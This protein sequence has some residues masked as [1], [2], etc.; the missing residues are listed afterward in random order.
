[1]K[2]G[3]KKFLKSFF[4]T[5]LAVLV[6]CVGLVVWVDPFFNY[7]IPKD[8][9]GYIYDQDYAPTWKVGISRHQKG[10][11]SIWVGSSLSTYVDVNYINQ[12]FNVNCTTGVIASGRPN[13]Y[14]MFIQNAID[15][16]EI[17]N[18]YYE[19]V[20][21]HWMWEPTGTDYDMSVIPEYIQT[22]AIFD[23]G[24][25]LFNKNVLEQAVLDLEGKR[26]TR[27]EQKRAQKENERGDNG[28]QNQIIPEDTLFSLEA[29]APRMYSN[30]M[31]NISEEDILKYK[32][33]GLKN[34][35]KNIVPL[36]ESNP[37]IEFWFVVPPTGVMN[38]SA[39]CNAGLIDPYIKAEKSIYLRLL[40]YKNVHVYFVKGDKEFNTNLNHYMDDGHFCPEGAY[41]EVDAIGTHK[42][43]LTKE[44]I[45]GV[46]EAA[47]K[48]AEDF[49]W[50]FLKVNFIGNDVAEFQEQLQ[51]LGYQTDEL[52]GFGTVTEQSVKK[53][54]EE[55]GLE[56]T[57]IAFEETRKMVSD[58]T[59]D[60]TK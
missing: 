6:L 7:R 11:D 48:D 32:K 44:N 59:N 14:H 18:V 16:N 20:V 3:N 2:D 60:T 47:K 36:I 29:M 40:E 17:K 57:G 33:I 43:E 26:K 5:L 56:S 52:G 41:L 28:A 45:D 1:M 55:H 4:I 21:T 34:V 58:M 13:I 15:K 42:Y 38:Y 35:E 30:T 51:A 27:A 50:P 37:D 39:M 9:S 19:T 10:C 53:F 12:K 25:Y 22:D 31:F 23:D 54:Q 46:M 49:V 8:T 24:D